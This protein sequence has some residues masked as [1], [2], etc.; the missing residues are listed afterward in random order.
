MSGV[1]L[2]RS[3]LKSLIEDMMIS[4]RGWVDAIIIVSQDG[5]PIA[6]SANMDLDPD[7][8]AAATSSIAGATDAVLELINSKGFDCVDVKLKEK[9]YFLIRRYRDYYVVAVTK[10]NPNLGFINLVFEAYLSR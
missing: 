10:P 9:R 1:E 5:A 7:Y 6:Y 4:C 3:E 8:V 2:A